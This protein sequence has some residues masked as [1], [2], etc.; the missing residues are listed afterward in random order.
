M[1]V[2]YNLGSP[3]GSTQQPFKDQSRTYRKA[4]SHLSDA[5]RIFHAVQS[6][7][8]VVTYNLGTPAPS[9]D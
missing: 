8:M 1:V 7:I 2:T 3:A 9:I 4:Y 6:L 5:F